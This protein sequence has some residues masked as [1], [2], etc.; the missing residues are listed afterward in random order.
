MTESRQ[1]EEESSDSQNEHQRQA[2]PVVEAFPLLD[3]KR[4]SLLQ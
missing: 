2:D 4:V 3:F 1:E